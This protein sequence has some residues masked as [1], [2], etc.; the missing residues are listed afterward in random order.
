M[1]KDKG[2]GVKGAKGGGKKAPGGGGKIDEWIKGAGGRS[3]G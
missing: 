3:I 2:K 1:A